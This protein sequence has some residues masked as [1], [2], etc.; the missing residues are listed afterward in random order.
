MSPP[1]TRIDSPRKVTEYPLR[2]PKDPNLVPPRNI[3]IITKPRIEPNASHT[4]PFKDY[5]IDP[6]ILPAT[7]I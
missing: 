4:T 2:I 7:Q 1:A 5:E 6:Y 3:P